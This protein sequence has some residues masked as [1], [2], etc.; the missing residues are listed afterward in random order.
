MIH[1]SAI[2][3]MFAGSPVHPLQQHMEKVFE[4]TCLLPS[5]VQALAAQ[6]FDEAES[7]QKQISKLENEADRLKHELR[8]NLPNSL[9]M[10]MPR[11]QILEIVTIQ[12]TIANKA[13]DIA[14]IM[15]G[16]QIQIPEP[17]TQVYTMFLKSSVEAVEQALEAV[18]ELDELVETGFRGGEV[19]LV[20]D[21][22]TKLNKIEYATDKHEQQIRHALFAIEKD[23]PPIDMMFLY[24]I[25][26]WTGEL[27]DIAQRVGSRLQ[28]LLAR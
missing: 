9:F 1:K 20:L 7:I 19:N 14:G 23:Y 3:S 15:M 21:L 11:G 16:R 25:I 18:N 26:D 8:N 27:A 2:T 17:I 6:S 28:L 24:Q 5:F 13:K 22:I 12:D 4:C 10:P